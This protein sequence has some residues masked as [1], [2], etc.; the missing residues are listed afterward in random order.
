MC[1]TRLPVPDRGRLRGRPTRHGRHRARTRRRTSASFAELVDSDHRPDAARSADR[2]RSGRPRGT[3]RPPELPA[4]RRVARESA[5]RDGSRNAAA[6]RGA[7][8]PRPTA[9]STPDHPPDHLPEEV[10]A[11]DA[12]QDERVVLLD[13]DGVD[14]HLRRFLIRVVGGE[15]LEVLQSDERARPP[16]AS[17]STDSGSRIHQTN[18][19]PNAVRRV[20]DL[21]EIAALDRVVPRMELVR[22]LRDAADVDV[23]RQL[24]VDLAPQ[25]LRCQFGVELQMRDLRQCMH[26]GVGSSGAIAARTP[27]GLSPHAR[28]DRSRPAP[29][30]RS[31]GSASRCISSR[32]IRSAV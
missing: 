22:R 23:G 11:A 27:A 8:S 29:S 10:R 7:I 15:G 1:S 17:L 19:L 4:P 12:D 9:A 31:A 20:R 32:R 26:A 18:G 28:R 6:S 25:Q 21:V 16:R 5:V 3:T 13:L 30:S 2:P 24:V 14:Q